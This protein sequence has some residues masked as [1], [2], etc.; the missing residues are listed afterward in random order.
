MDV[1]QSHIRYAYAM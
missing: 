1:K